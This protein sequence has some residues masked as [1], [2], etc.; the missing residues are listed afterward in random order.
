VKFHAIKGFNWI[1]IWYQ[2]CWL[3]II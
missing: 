2:V 1:I 3:R